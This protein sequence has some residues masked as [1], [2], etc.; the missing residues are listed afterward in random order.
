M[1]GQ[2]MRKKSSPSSGLLTRLD[3]RKVRLLSVD[4]PNWTSM[5]GEYRHKRLLE[6]GNTLLDLGHFYMLWV[7]QEYIPKVW[8]EKLEHLN[9]RVIISF[10]GTTLEDRFGNKAVMTMT[11]H[12]GKWEYYPM[13]F[14]DEFFPHV[15]SAVLP[16]E[17]EG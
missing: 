9:R 12:H 13:D 11:M 8:E 1:V 16:P 14:N 6:S 15:K 3:M 10:D 17:T 2:L 7:F 4:N 5:H